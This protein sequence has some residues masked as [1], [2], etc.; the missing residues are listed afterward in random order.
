MSDLFE[1]KKQFDASDIERYQNGSM[2]A[3]ERHALEKAA[4]DDPFLADALEGYQFTATP[5]QDLALLQKRLQEKTQRKKVFPLFTK[6]YTWLK[7]AAMF[8]VVAGAAW[9]FYNNSLVEQKD[10]AVT[11]ETENNKLSAPVLKTDTTSA[12]DVATA[13]PKDESSTKTILTPTNKENISTRLKEKKNNEVVFENDAKQ[14]QNAAAQLQTMN[15]RLAKGNVANNKAAESREVLQENVAVETNRKLVNDST[16]V[17]SAYGIKRERAIAKSD[18]IK[19]LNIVLTPSSEPPKE[20]VLNKNPRKKDSAKPFVTI[21]ESEP[22]GGF[23]S[24][25]DYV[26]EH[27]KQPEGLKD[28][29]EAGDVKLSFDINDKG[30]AT[31]IKVE[32][33]LCATC[34]EE[35]IRLLK[36]GPKWK[37]KKNKKGKLTIHF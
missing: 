13:Q 14:N 36:E 15:T 24:F 2:S 12:A 33:S 8:L 19:D 29:P 21:E 34:D 27:L 35:A 28:K 16:A 23:I 17:V 31:N 4:L 20:V 22:A 11:R 25:N 30:E 6:Q 32:K 26:A 9:I 7:V 37:Q 5:Q 1:N 3:A 10:V 18:T